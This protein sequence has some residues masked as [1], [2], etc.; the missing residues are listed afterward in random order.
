M[1][2]DKKLL[3]AARREL[4]RERTAHTAELEAAALREVDGRARGVERLGHA[5]QH[6]VQK[7]RHVVGP[8]RGHDDGQGARKALVRRPELR[9]QALRL[10]VVRILFLEAPDGHDVAMLMGV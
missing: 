8:H 2:Y 4:E 10:A 5:V 7:R 6:R 3:A 1:A 9:E